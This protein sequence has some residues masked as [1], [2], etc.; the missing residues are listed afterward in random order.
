MTMRSA[1][2]ATAALLVTAVLLLGVAIAIHHNPLGSVDSGVLK[3]MIAH[4]TAGVTSVATVLTDMFSPVWVGIW[5]VVAAGVCLASDR[6]VAR[7]AALLATVA[8]AGFVCEIIKLAVN[9]L[10]PPPIDQVASPEVAMSFPSGHVSGTAAL[11][12]GVAVIA[13]VGSHPRRRLAAMVVA[14]AIAVVAAGTRLYLGAHWLS[15][16]TAA[17]AVAGAVALVVPTLTARAL[18]VIEPH[19]PTGWHHVLTPRTLTPAKG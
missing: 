7:G 1:R 9:R 3:W 13:T 8:V 19:T 17:I 12:F 6:T 15:D 4:R 14:V 10:R 11:A 16:V 5:T 2:T 18:T